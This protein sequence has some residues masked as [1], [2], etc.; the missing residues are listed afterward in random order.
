MFVPSQVYAMDVSLITPVFQA[1]NFLN[2]Y[3]NYK[4]YPPMEDP[5][6]VVHKQVITRLKTDPYINQNTT[7][8]VLHTYP[9]KEFTSADE[10]GIACERSDGTWEIMD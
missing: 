6:Y 2:T 9:C 10:S 1:L 7:V 3:D 4:K 8:E 5:P